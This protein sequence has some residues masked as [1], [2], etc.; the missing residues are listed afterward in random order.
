MERPYRMK[1]GLKNTYATSIRQFHADSLKWAVSYNAFPGVSLSTSTWTGGKKGDNIVLDL[2]QTAPNGME[3]L[4]RLTF[5]DINA[6]GFNWKGEWV[7]E[8]ANIVYPFW[9][10][11]CKKGCRHLA[12]KNF[13]G[14]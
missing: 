10:I 1:P 13:P 3:G 8:D 7:K 6:E 14:K 11:W 9:Y 12:Y 4:S 5:Y 2:P